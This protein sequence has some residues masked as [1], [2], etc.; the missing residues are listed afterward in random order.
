[1]VI[2]SLCV[3]VHSHR[4]ISN[5]LPDQTESLLKESKTSVDEGDRKAQPLWRATYQL[6]DLLP[7]KELGCEVVHPS[8]QVLKLLL[9]EPRIAAK[10]ISDVIRINSHISKKAHNWGNI[11]VKVQLDSKSKLIVCVPQVKWHPKIHQ[12]F[13]SGALLH[14]GCQCL[15]WMGGSN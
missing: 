3:V 8:V 2:Q 13:Q 4:H 7:A 5:F 11:S 1:M 10:D 12:S 9:K 6:D 14:Q 15:S